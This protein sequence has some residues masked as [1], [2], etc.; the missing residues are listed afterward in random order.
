MNSSLDNITTAPVCWFHGIFICQAWIAISV[1]SER[2]N[3][4][5]DDSTGRER[6]KRWQNSLN[7]SAWRFISRKAKSARCGW[8]I[9]E[10]GKTNYKNAEKTNYKNTFSDR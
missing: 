10:N 5:C 6:R 2:K 1:Q 9:K 4:K 7:K 8:F 3:G